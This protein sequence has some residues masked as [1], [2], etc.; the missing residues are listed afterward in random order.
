MALKF[1]KTSNYDK[2]YIGVEYN[3]PHLYLLNT[4][5]DERAWYIYTKLGPNYVCQEGMEE[6]LRG[7]SI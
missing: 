5:G 4:K 7:E 2:V 6:V 1:I 3:I